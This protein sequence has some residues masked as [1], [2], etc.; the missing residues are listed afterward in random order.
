MH[1]AIEAFEKSSEKLLK[2]FPFLFSLKV[3]S[4]AQWFSGKKISAKREPQTHQ[5]I[6]FPI[7]AIDIFSEV[8]LRNNKTF[9]DM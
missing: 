1:L 6:D 4:S 9:Y 2:N 3:N 8:E 7:Q 5:T